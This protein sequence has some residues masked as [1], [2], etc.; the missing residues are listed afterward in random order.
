MIDYDDDNDDDDD[1]DDN[2]NDN[3]NDDDDNDNDDD[4]VELCSVMTSYLPVGYRLDRGNPEKRK[5]KEASRKQVS[6]RY[7]PFD[8]VEWGPQRRD[9]HLANCWSSLKLWLAYNAVHC[10]TDP[11]AVRTL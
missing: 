6:S 4:D 1:D 7:Q 5:S 3:D 8:L 10:V 2:D 9:S 11:R